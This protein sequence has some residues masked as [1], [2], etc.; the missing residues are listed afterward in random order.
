[1]TTQPTPPARQGHARLLLERAA[2]A[3]RNR[4]RLRQLTQLTDSL[5]PD[6]AAADML[7]QLSLGLGEIMQS[8][9][10]SYAEAADLLSLNLDIESGRAEEPQ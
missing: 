2:T 10:R 6:Q 3:A 5:I 1:M 8:L 9:A 4:D 7:R